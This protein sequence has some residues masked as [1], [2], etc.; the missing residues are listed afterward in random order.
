MSGRQRGWTIIVLWCVGWASLG[1]AR[2]Q[3]A[4]PQEHI[5]NWAPLFVG[6][7]IFSFY[8]L[9]ALNVLYRGFRTFFR[10]LLSKDDAT[11]G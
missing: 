5:W 7:M 8:L 6:I 1:V 2:L 11:R 10:V 4:E 3:A 9:G